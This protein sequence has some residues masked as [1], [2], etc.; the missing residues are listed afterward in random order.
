MKRAVAAA[1]QGEQVL[2]VEV[3]AILHLGPIV[4][5]IHDGVSILGNI[6]LGEKTGAAKFL[7]DRLID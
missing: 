5:N 3:D 1:D 4:P 7:V 2:A 6:V